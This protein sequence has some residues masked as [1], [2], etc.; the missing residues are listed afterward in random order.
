MQLRPHIHNVLWNKAF[1]N[2][3]FDFKMFVTFKK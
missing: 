3:D 2:T 1:Y